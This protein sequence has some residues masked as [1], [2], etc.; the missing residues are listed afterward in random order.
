MNFFQIGVET[1]RVTTLLCNFYI[2]CMEFPNGDTF[3]L[4]QGNFFIGVLFTWKL[5][6]SF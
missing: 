3:R 1:F 2:F 4:G 6:I 5:V